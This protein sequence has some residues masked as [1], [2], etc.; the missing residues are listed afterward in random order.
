[1]KPTIVAFSISTLEPVLREVSLDLLPEADIE[2]VPKAYEDALVY[3]SAAIRP[4]Q[5]K[6]LLRPVPTAPTSKTS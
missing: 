1:M 6:C 3:A 4:A 2:I 5:L